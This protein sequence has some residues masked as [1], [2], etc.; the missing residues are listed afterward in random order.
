MIAASYLLTCVNLS[1]SLLEATLDFSSSLFSDS[2]KPDPGPLTAADN[3]TITRIRE[4]PDI[5]NQAKDIDIAMY[6]VTVRYSEP[7]TFER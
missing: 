5:T 1:A 6:L 2:K 7:M 3:P 4:W